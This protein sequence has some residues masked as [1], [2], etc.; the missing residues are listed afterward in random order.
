MGYYQYIKSGLL[1]TSHDVVFKLR[2]I[3]KTKKI[4]HTGTLDPEVAGV[5]P[6]CIG[7]ATRVSDYVMD[8]GKAYEATV[9]IGEIQRLSI[10]RVIHWKQ[11]VY[12][13][14]ILIRTILTDC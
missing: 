1:L 8:M 6:V 7:N 2:K 12:T 3:L 4:G 10:K 11:K 14:Q 9:S 13:Q 5:L